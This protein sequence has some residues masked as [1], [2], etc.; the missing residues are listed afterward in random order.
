M[1][2][3]L[4]ARDL[5]SAVAE[6]KAYLAR[7]RYPDLDVDTALAK[8]RAS[9][10]RYKNE[11]FPALYRDEEPDPAPWNAYIDFGH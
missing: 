2:A 3:E 6:L 7:L 9:I 10:D 11:H 1:W 5:W 4:D 8:A